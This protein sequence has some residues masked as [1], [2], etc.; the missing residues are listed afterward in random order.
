[1]AFSSDIAAAYVNGIRVEY[2]PT[3]VQM[4]VKILNP[5]LY[6]AEQQTDCRSSF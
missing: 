6:Q 2:T 4:R 3:L 1:M 5:T